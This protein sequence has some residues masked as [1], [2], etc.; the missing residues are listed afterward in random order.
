[1]TSRP[2]RVKRTDTLFPYTTL[3]RSLVALL[4]ELAG[5]V[6][7]ARHHVVLAIHWRHALRRL[8]QDQAVH[9]VGDVHADRRG[10]A[11]VDEQAGVERLEGEAADVTRRGEQIGRAH[12]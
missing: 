2:P 4:A 3:F 11:V 1:M 7:V 8:D 12:V 9:A 5:G 10:G 6:E